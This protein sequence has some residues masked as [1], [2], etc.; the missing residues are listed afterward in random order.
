MSFSRLFLGLGATTAAAAIV[1]SHPS[2]AQTIPN[3][4][5]GGCPVSTMALNAMFKSGSVAPD[6]E[7]KPADSTVAIGSFCGFFDWSEQMFL[8]LTSPAPK[9]YGG[10]GGRIMFSP[11][12]YTVTPIDQVTGRRSFIRN[13]PRL[14]I[15][16]FLRTT[17]LGPHMRPALISKTGQVIEVQ[18]QDPRRPA[19]PLVRLQS[20]ATA[21]VA[22]IRRGAGGALQFLDAAGRALQ[23]R[24]LAG[25]T[26]KRQMIQM[27][28]GRKVAMLPVSTVRDAVAARKFVFKGV[29][30]FFDLNGNVIDVE[31]GQADFGVLLSQNGSLI[32]YITSVNDVF[33]Y[34]RTMQGAAAIPDPT[35]LAFPMTMADANTIKAFAATKGHTIVDPEALA[36]ETKSSW[37]EASA[38]PNPQDYVQVTATVPTF[39]KSNPDMWVPN[40]QANVKLVMVGIH[41]VGSTN[42]HGEM[43]WG[44]FEH[45]GNAPNAQYQYNSTVGPNPKTV[46]QNSVGTW[47]FTPSGAGTPFNISHAFWDEPTGS[48]QGVPGG[49]PVAPT[50]ILR[51]SPWGMPGSNASSNTNLISLNSSVITQLLGGDVRKN[52]FQLGTTWTFGGA[53]PENPGSQTGTTQLANATIESFVQANPLASPPTTGLTCFSCHGSNTVNVSHIFG[54]LK[55]LP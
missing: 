11:S 8:W 14:P 26:V 12:F 23:V 43:L 45:F 21:R 5:Q 3:D 51:A 2:S 17:E 6:G 48:I 42:G 13:D 24:R 39:D 16:M 40:G 27:Q 50:P 1:L 31:P 46:A 54:V 29:P 32:Y 49:S 4:A 28:D 44:T 33:A 52:Y 18:R 22:D 15:K 9:S 35:A 55:P 41:V 53:P 19:A 47:L 38:V 10:G 30:V 34:Y 20:G 25:P 36:I 7:V 37:I